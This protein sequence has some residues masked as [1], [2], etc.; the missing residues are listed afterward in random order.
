MLSSHSATVTALA[1]AIG[2]QDGK[3]GVAFAIVVALACVVRTL[4][5]GFTLLICFQFFVIVFLCLLLVHSLMCRLFTI[6]PAALELI[7]FVFYYSD[8]DIF[9]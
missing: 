5:P 9:I 4:K 1:V 8:S 7:I 3:G 2:L 6:F